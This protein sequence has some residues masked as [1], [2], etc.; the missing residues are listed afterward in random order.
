MA[1]ICQSELDKWQ[2]RI[3][4]WTE[5]YD[6]VDKL[7][8]DALAAEAQAA[9]TC[10]IAVRVSVTIIAGVIGGGACAVAVARLTQAAMAL[11]DG[12]DKANDKAARCD[13]QGA[14]FFKC[15]ADHK[16]DP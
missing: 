2:D 6:A 15:L 13:E 5:A 12:V 1:P 14:A 11:S 8:D 10:G 9:T 3:R 4:E 16:K 7:F